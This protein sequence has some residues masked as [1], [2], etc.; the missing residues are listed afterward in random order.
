VEREADTRRLSRRD[1]DEQGV[2][3]MSSGYPIEAQV[4]NVSSNGCLIR[5]LALLPIGAVVCIEMEPFG[6]RKARVIHRSGQAYGCEFITSAVSTSITDAA[7][8][9]SSSA[10]V[11]TLRSSLTAALWIAI[12][13]AVLALP[14]LLISTLFYLGLSWYLT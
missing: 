13:V 4:E 5:S 14:W 8:L 10:R 6:I 1:V 9:I 11:G 7:E 12:A 3:W 2:L